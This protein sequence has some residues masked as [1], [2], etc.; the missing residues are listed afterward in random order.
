[1]SEGGGG[2]QVDVH[3]LLPWHPEM[4]DVL[5]SLVI[6]CNSYFIPSDLCQ[7]YFGL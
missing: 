6:L 2:V 5:K 3:L 1:M 7:K 4:E